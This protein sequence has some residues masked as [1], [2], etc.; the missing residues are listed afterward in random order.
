MLKK[1]DNQDIIFEAIE[2]LYNI[3]KN[4]IVILKNT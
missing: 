2:D 1:S 4:G 3:F